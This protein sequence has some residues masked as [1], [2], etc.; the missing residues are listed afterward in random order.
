M[1]EEGGG[2]LR[3]G[4][5]LYILSA[6]KKITTGCLYCVVDVFGHNLGRE[7]MYESYKVARLSGVME[8]QGVRKVGR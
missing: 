1:E 3:G 6:Q 2:D 7:R 8:L 5:R 4:T